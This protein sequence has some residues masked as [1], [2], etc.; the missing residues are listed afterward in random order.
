MK[1]NKILLLFLMILILTSCGTKKTE[2]QKEVVEQETPLT[3]EENADS[4]EEEEEKVAFDLSFINTVDL[5]GNEIDATIFENKYTLVNIWGTFC[6]PCIVE[7]PDLQKLHANLGGD[8]FQVIGIISDTHVDYENNIEDAKNIIEKTGVEYINIIP[9]QQLIEE[10][11]TNIQF[12]PTS[13][14]VDSQGKI[15]GEMVFGARD[16]NFF[17]SWVNSTK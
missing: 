9:N 2:E 11:L 14:I 12:V 7:M 1:K 15:V 16:Y 3:S 17:E 4:E 13:F 10:V 5:N 6:R 8:E